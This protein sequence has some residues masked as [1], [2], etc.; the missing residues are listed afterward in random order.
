MVTSIDVAGG[1]HRVVD[2]FKA[3]VP[4]IESDGLRQA[5]GGLEVTA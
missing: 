4:R 2:V 1:A 5:G 3:Q